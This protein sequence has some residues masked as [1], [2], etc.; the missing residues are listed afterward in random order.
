DD[1]AMVL[2]DPRFGRDDTQALSQE[3]IREREN[4]FPEEARPALAMMRNWMLYRD[5][6][7][8][9][10]LRMLVHKAFTPRT[11]ERLKPALEGIVTELLDAMDGQGRVDLVEALA[12]PLPV[13]VIAEL[14]GVPGADRGKFRCWSHTIFAMLEGTRDPEVFRLGGIATMEFTA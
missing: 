8:H 14:V 13:N 12:Y 4:P 5:P 3:A 9:T 6:P 7:V 10:R 2:K 11:V 1:C